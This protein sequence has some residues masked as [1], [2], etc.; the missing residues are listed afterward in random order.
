MTRPTRSAGDTPRV[1]RSDAHGAVRDALRCYVGPGRAWKSIDLAS[2]AG[3]PVKSIEC[4]LAQVGSEHWRPIPFD[5]L[6][7][8]AAV[9]GGAF[10]TGCLRPAS[11]GAF[12]LP[13]AA[14]LDPAALMIEKL[15]L[16]NAVVALAADNDLSADD[17][18]KMIPIANAGLELNM[19][20][21]A[22]H[23]AGIP[24]AGA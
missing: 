9:L 20:M 12:V 3:V 14:A 7:S 19:Q 11:L 16:A 22:A 24:R 15:R 5:R 17:L 1:P 23:A 6:L 10:A 2:E 13:S 8:I 21:L 4:A 18:E